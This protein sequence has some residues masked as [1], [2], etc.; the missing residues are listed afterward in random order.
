MSKGLFCGKWKLLLLTLFILPLS[1]G[2]Y[3]CGGGGD[4]DGGGGSPAPTAPESVN[5]TIS[6]L[7]NP[8]P[9]REL[10]GA[11]VAMGG[12][13]FTVQLLGIEPPGI[14]GTYNLS[15]EAMRLNFGAFRYITSVYNAYTSIGVSIAEPIDLLAGDN[16]TAGRLDVV[17]TT[18]EPAPAYTYLTLSFSNTGVRIRTYTQPGGPPIA[19]NGDLSYTWL[20]FE[21]VDDSFPENVQFAKFSYGIWSFLLKQVGI[22][23]DALEKILDNED[24]LADGN[25]TLTGAALPWAPGQS[26]R[27]VINASGSGVSPGDDFVLTYTNWWIDDLADN[28]DDLFNGL[29]TLFG[30]VEINGE[31]PLGGD[32]VF[33][34]FIK[35]ETENNQAPSG[36]TVTVN[37][38]FALI[39]DW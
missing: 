2:T 10:L 13:N 32:F 34:N 27:I 28:I 11:S 5:F 7:W 14:T 4:D 29:L 21:E 35:Q 38:G 20:Q 33:T 19:V 18:T 31:P 26:G 22:I 15:S 30:Y 12:D 24:E 36:D 37:G 17:I 23:F 16:P 3:G 39:V 9:G 8:G 1:I 6:E 25:E